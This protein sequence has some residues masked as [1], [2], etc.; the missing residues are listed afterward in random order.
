[1]RE[2][3]VTPEGQEVSLGAVFEEKL[4]LGYQ[5]GARRLSPAQKVASS[6]AINF[7]QIIAPVS[8]YQKYKNWLVGW[9]E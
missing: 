9:L 8:V 1:M 5:K 6:S 2:K 7:C 4:F 3:K